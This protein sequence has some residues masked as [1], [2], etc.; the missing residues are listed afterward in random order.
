MGYLG[1]IYVVYF[2][3]IAVGTFII[4]KLNLSKYFFGYRL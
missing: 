4:R 2:K 3:T 1:T